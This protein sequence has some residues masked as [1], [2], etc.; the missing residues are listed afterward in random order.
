MSTQLTQIPTL[1]IASGLGGI[2]HPNP[3]PYIIRDSLYNDILTEQGLQLHWQQ[4]L[5]PDPTLHKL[6]AIADLN[7]RLAAQTARLS[8]QGKPFLVIG[9]DHSCAMGTWAGVLNALDGA[10]SLGLFWL[11][12]HMDAHTFESSPSGNL[13]GMPLAALLGDDSLKG[14]Y[15][16]SQ[17]IQASQLCLLGTRSYEQAEKELL[18]AK[19]TVV[20]FREDIDRAVPSIQSLAASTDQLALSL[21]LDLL[22]PE[23]AP[24]VD[25]PVANGLALEEL[26]ALLDSI[27]AHS[28]L[29]ACEI[30]EFCPANDYNRVTE[31][32]IFQL[33]AKLFQQQS[34]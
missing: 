2:S 27:T 22:A 4:I 13:H 1:G 7:Q 28:S 26:F 30:C 11:D 18:I 6:A 12:A 16:S 5:E 23:I 29:M 17:Y 3:A 19:N 32:T 8:R 14:L 25:T 33:I 34:E 15:P 21:D 24:A 20:I 10:S 31:H 9:G